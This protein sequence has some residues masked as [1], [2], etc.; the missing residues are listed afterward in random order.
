MW[1]V[2]GAGLPHSMA[3]SGSWTSYMMMT[4]G[5]KNEY[6]SKQMESHVVRKTELSCRT[7]H[8]EGI[9]MLQVSST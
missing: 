1:P 6:S 4:E 3:A 9:E 2:S 5:S 7:G 8:I